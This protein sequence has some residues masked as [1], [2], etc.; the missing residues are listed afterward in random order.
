VTVEALV[1]SPLAHRA[2]DLAAFGAAEIPALAQ[3]DLRVGPALA[4]RVP[5]PLP[6]RPNTFVAGPSADVLWLGPDEWLMVAPAGTGHELLA[7]LDEALAGE[8]RSVVD[9]SASR[10]VLDLTGPSA[11]EL[12]SRGCGLD[13]HPRSWGPADCAQTLLARVAVI[14]QQRDAATRIFVR[15]S[16]GDYLV[17]WLL[18]AGV[19]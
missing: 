6:A 16:F 9:V 17:D 14:L 4:H 13:L 19:R 2:D 11:L 12:L 3:I 8:H 10:S 18:D 15:P 7:E 1:R 5:L